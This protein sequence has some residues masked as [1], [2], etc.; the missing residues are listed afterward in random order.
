MKQQDSYFNS[1]HSETDMEKGFLVQ[2]ADQDVMMLMFWSTLNEQ[3]LT[4]LWAGLAGQ[5]SGEFHLFSLTNT[6][7]DFKW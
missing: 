1:A 6:D 5:S 2:S 7:V 4:F 3:N